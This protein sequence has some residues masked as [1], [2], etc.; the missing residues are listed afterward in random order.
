MKNSNIS[1]E[2]FWDCSKWLFTT[3][4]GSGHCALLSTYVRTGRRGRRFSNVNIHQR[5]PELTVMH[6][7]FSSRSGVWNYMLK[8]AYKYSL[9]KTGGLLLS[10]L[11]RLQSLEEQPVSWHSGHTESLPSNKLKYRLYGWWIPICQ[12]NAVRS[13][14][15][16]QG[17]LLGTCLV[18]EC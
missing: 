6:W 16:Q 7:D 5:A 18:R 12:V 9:S 14:P 13:N 1:G 10:L 2:N 15:S 11:T 17:C 8:M 4:P 3:S